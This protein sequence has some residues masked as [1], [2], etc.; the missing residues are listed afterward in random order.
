MDKRESI[1]CDQL[2]LLE[3]A[4]WEKEYQ[5]VCNQYRFNP[6]ENTRK[7]SYAENIIEI[8]LFPLQ[9]VLI[10]NISLEQRKALEIPYIKWMSS[11]YAPREYSANI[12]KTIGKIIRTGQNTEGNDIDVLKKELSRDEHFSQDPYSTRVI[13]ALS[14]ATAFILIALH[15]P[16]EGKRIA[17]EQR[18]QAEIEKQGYKNCEQFFNDHECCETINLISQNVAKQY[19][20]ISNASDLDPDDIDDTLII[21]LASEYWNKKL[22]TKLYASQ[23]SS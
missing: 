1:L 17:E 5:S 7:E 3:K 16:E 12:L 11:L 14:N 6:T 22:R 2:V 8:L 9:H 4:L 13:K 18:K 10:N 23:L 19:E 15:D 20:K 21:T